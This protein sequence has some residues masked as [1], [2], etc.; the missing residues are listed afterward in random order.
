MRLFLAALFVFAGLILAIILFGGL[1]DRFPPLLTGTVMALLF[2]V[3]CGIALEVFN[4]LP[5]KPSPPFVSPIPAVSTDY[6]A[7]RAL[8]VEEEEEACYIIELEDGS[9]LV[10]WQFT[11]GWDEEEETIP[12]PCT[13]FTVIRHE[14]HIVAVDRRG[15]PIEADIASP[16]FWDS[17]QGPF[18]TNGQVFTDR[19]YDQIQGL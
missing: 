13:D 10:I 2:L 3:L 4:A 11:L 8:V 17:W 9:L 5:E 6:R 15:Q 19:T 16:N 1:I 18:P 7:K 12:F 14:G